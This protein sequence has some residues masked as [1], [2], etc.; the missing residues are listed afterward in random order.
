MATPPRAQAPTA[1]AHVLA[2]PQWVIG[3][4]TGFQVTCTCGW[5]SPLVDT[6][7]LARSVA[8]DHT[9]GPRP[10]TEAPIGSYVRV[11]QARTAQSCQVPSMPLSSW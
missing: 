4:E 1:T 6:A 11:G 3:R 9:A 10:R 5:V 7:S 2:E 8:F